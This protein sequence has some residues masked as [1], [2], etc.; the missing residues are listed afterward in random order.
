M[1]SPQVSIQGKKREKKKIV[2][3]VRERALHEFKCKSEKNH[4]IKR[5]QGKS[6]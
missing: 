3:A 6:K 4:L 5:T 1:I 2:N